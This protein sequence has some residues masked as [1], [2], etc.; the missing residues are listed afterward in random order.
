MLERRVRGL[1]AQTTRR[2]AVIPL[3]AGETDDEARAHHLAANPDDRDA[4]LTVF[5]RHFFMPRPG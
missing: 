1:E 3:Y 2:V 5:V 4:A